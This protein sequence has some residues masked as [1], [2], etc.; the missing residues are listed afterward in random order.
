MKDLENNV[1]ADASARHQATAAC[2]ISIIFVSY[3]V[4]EMKNYKV[5]FICRISSRVE[6]QKKLTKILN[7]RN[8]RTNSKVEHVVSMVYCNLVESIP[9]QRYFC[10]LNNIRRD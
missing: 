7:Q 9:D 4:R 10:G 5:Q 6:Y 3:G 2:L 8:A 1:A